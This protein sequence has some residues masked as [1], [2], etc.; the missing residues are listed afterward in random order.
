MMCLPFWVDLGILHGSKTDSPEKEGIASRK[1]I[2]GYL[3]VHENLSLPTELMNPNL[4][5][6]V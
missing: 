2:V 6:E 3:K 1:G 5:R 4:D